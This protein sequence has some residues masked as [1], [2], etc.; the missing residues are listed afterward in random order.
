MTTQFRI[1]DSPHTQSQHPFLPF[2][3]Q[4]PLHKPQIP[5]VQQAIRTRLIDITYPKEPRHS[6][7]DQPELYTRTCT[8]GS[9]ELKG[10]QCTRTNGLCTRVSGRAVCVDTRAEMMGLRR[11]MEC[12][13]ELYRALSQ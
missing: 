9:R 5:T 2:P 12:W 10:I 3:P 6:L 8:M 1:L 11:T 4:S 13:R 7:I